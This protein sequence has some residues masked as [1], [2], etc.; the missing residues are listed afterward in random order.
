MTETD[1]TPLEKELT[2]LADKAIAR[3]AAAYRR[4]AEAAAAAAASAEEA[5]LAAIMR[6]CLHAE[7][8]AAPWMQV[9]SLVA[10]GKTRT[11]A[12]RLVFR[13]ASR[14]LLSGRERNAFGTSAEQDYAEREGLRTFVQDVAP[15]IGEKI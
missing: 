10:L 15:L 9:Q 3:R 14:E 12:T 1:A 11:E 6:D 13:K 2:G 4:L 8:A 7:A 5:D